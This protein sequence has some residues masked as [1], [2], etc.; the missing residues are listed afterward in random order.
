MLFKEYHILLFFQKDFFFTSYNDEKLKKSKKIKN[1]EDNI[2]K[3]VRNLF[4]LKTKQMT[5]QLKTKETYLD[6]KKKMKQ[7]KTEQ[8]EIL[9]TILNI[10]GKIIK[11]W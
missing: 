1:I 3:D 2:V 9:G 5:P 7:S 8:V 6:Q 4:T 10:K 11:N